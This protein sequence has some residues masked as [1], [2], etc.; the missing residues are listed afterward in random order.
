MENLVKI[1]GIKIATILLSI[2]P[3]DLEYKRREE[4]SS[5]LREAA[6]VGNG[7]IDFDQ[8]SM[9][10]WKNGW[11]MERPVRTGYKLSG[12][13]CGFVQNVCSPT[14]RACVGGRR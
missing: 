10:L 12:A 8:K 1:V 6:G 14:A 5:P 11:Q 3:R 13:E 7:A 2:P 4:Y 9:S